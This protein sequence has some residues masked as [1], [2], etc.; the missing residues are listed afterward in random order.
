MG[1]P[2]RLGGPYRRDGDHASAEYPRGALVNAA[3]AECS[4]RHRRCRRVALRRQLAAPAPL[5]PLA[6]VETGD[7]L[8]GTRAP[9]YLR[10]C[11]DGAPVRFRFLE[12]ATE[13][14]NSQGKDG[15]LA[16]RRQLRRDDLN[17][18]IAPYVSHFS[19]FVTPYFPIH[20]TPSFFSG[21]LQEGEATVVWRE[22]AG[23]HLRLSAYF[24]AKLCAELPLSLALSAILALGTHALAQLASPALLY[25]RITALEM[26]AG[27]ALGMCVGALSPSL[28]LAME[29][30]KAVMMTFTIFGG[31]YFDESTLPAALSWLPRAS[32]APIFSVVT[33]QFPQLS[34]PIFF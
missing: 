30:G 21:V 13:R 7:G 26:L 27:S 24:I 18:E 33:P 14:L 8:Q 12:A 10:D 1:A 23:G 16:G 29:I 3:A 11:C 28:E 32:L 5:V 17:D 20:H 4:W 34:H 31:L 15:T 6:I 19:P 25:A 9:P 22:R 2:A